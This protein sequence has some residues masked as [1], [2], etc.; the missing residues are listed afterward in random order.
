MA[1]AGHLADRTGASVEMVSVYAP[2]IPLPACPG[3]DGFDQCEGGERGGAVAVLRAVRRQRRQTG[4]VHDW[5]LRLAVGAP[6]A[7]IV[8]LAAEVGADL[9]V[10]GIGAPDATSTETAARVAQFMTAPMLAAVAGCELPSSGIVVASSGNVHAPTMEA[11]VVCLTPGSRLWIANDDNAADVLHAVD[12]Y[13]AQLVA[14][15][16]WGDPGPV[17]AFLPNAAVPLL[18]AARCSVLIVPD[19]R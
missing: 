4:H 7:V 14:V 17:R 3:R 11:A 19:A 2:R 18:L 13:S 5:P 1:A 12:E 8:R 16:L 10:L 6:D 15:H 9:V